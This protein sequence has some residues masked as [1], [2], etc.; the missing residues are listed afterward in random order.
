MADIVKAVKN[1]LTLEKVLSTAMWT[2]GVKI[3]RAKFLKK[4][5]I[6]YC[7]E[8]TIANAV[9]SSKSGY[10]QGNNK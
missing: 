5:L 2:P 1:E 6:R 9:K 4:E 3:N 7:D 8:E 10:K